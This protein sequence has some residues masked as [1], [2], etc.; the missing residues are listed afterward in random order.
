MFSVAGKWGEVDKSLD[1]FFVDIHNLPQ[2]GRVRYYR[3][4]E[5]EI[6]YEKVS[7]ISWSFSLAWYSS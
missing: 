3:N 7:D 4:I 5:G 1:A 6:E 2:L